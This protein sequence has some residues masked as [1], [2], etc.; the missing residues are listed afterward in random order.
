MTSA[1]AAS[2]AA[3][4]RRARVPALRFPL[5][6]GRGFIATRMMVFAVTLV[7]ITAILMGA[8]SYTRARTAL[9]TEA[10]ARLSLLAHAVAEHLHMQIE[11]RAADITNWSH[12]EVMHALLYRD[13]DKELAEFTRQ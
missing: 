11:D 6:V 9:K 5:A 1:P 8:L 10:R 7:S 4:A 13:V 3:R 2:A 12:L